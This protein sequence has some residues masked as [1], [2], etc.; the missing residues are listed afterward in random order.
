M[1]WDW[2]TGIVAA[3]VVLA[4]SGHVLRAQA[5]APA[6]TPRAA[7]AAP[8]GNAQNGQ[9]LYNKYGCYQCHGRE[10]QGSPGTGPRLGPNPLPLAGF[11]RYIRAPR[12]QMPPYTDKVLTEREAADIHAF[13]AARPRPPAVQTVLPPE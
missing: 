11:L 4:S 9:Q 13:L 2:L 7:A 6:Q 8:A 10:G 3:L 5:P 12:D 1:K